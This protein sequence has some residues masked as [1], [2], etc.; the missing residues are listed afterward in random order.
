M[1]PGLALLL[2][3]CVWLWVN[4]N[5]SE[6]LLSYVKRKII[7]F[8]NG[9]WIVRMTFFN[10]RQIVRTTSLEQPCSLLPTNCTFLHSRSFFFSERFVSGVS[11]LPKFLQYSSTIIVHWNINYAVIIFTIRYIFLYFYIPSLSHIYILAPLHP[12][13]AKP[14]WSE[15]CILHHFFIGQTCSHYLYKILTR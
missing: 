1:V 14:F 10:D 2:M 15:L 3:N 9:R 4:L 11:T 8:A 6:Y 7:I 5:L 13:N 12:Q